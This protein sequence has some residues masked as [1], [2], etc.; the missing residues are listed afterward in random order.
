MPPGRGLGMS[1]VRHDWICQLRRF[2]PMLVSHR[3]S[4]ISHAR[5][6]RQDE[7]DVL[8]RTNA[9]RSFLAGTEIG[10]FPGRATANPQPSS[11]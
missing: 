9:Q 8:H 2:A 10:V 6:A 11:P 7:Q 3:R 5:F 4:I 1:T